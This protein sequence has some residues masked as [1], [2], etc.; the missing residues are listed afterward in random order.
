MPHV[1]WY[2]ISGKSIKLLGRD[3]YNTLVAKLMKYIMTTAEPTYKL[4]I[5]FGVSCT[6]YENQVTRRKKNSN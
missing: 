1:K 4:K 3:Q 5:F 2:E 6:P